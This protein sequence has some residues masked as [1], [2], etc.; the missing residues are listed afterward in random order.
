MIN[1]E[2]Y[3]EPYNHAILLSVIRKYLFNKMPYELHALE[4]ISPRLCAV[5]CT[6]I[7]KLMYP[8]KHVY[9]YKYI[10]KYKYSLYKLR[11]VM[12]YNNEYKLPQA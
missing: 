3:E 9:L 2:K 1:F 12:F 10:Y 6:L 8:N 4:N 5:K 7:F 11:D